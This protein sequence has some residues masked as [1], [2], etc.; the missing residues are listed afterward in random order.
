M[1]ANEIPATVAEVADPVAVPSAAEGP[2]AAPVFAEAAPEESG[3]ELVLVGGGMA[4]ALGL[5]GL[6]M[7]GASRRRRAARPGAATPVRN[8]P[9]EPRAQPVRTAPPAPAAPAAAPALRPGP[10][11]VVTASNP[12]PTYAS[13]WHSDGY[14]NAT[15]AAP[16]AGRSV[17]NTPEGRKA[18]I[19]RLVRARPDATIPFTSSAARRRRARLIVQ[20]LQQR[21]AEQPNLDFR[22]FYESF[23]RRQPAS[24]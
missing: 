4:V 20:S 10:G 2:S 15:P 12:A 14:V 8:A 13:K 17:P 24:A 7:A 6:F 5:A 11:F 3:S 19:D 18:L 9:I 16:V 21:L 22:R 23:G 1:V